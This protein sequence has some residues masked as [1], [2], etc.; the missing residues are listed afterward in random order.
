MNMN[1]I[2]FSSIQKRLFSAT[3]WNVLGNGFAR[4]IM[5]IASIFL[6]QILG[7]EDFGKWGIIRSTLSMFTLFLTFSLSV[8]AIRHLAEYRK[9]NIEK[10]G[11]ILTLSFLISII[12][13]SIITILIFL[14]AKPIAISILNDLTISVPLQIASVFI[15]LM[16]LNSVL[17][18]ALSGLENFKLIA[19][20]NFIAG[21]L[22]APLIILLTNEYSLNGITLGYVIYYMILFICLFYFFYKEIKKFHIKFVFKNLKSELPVFYKFS[23]PALISGAIGAPIVF[24][25]YSY[26][27]NLEN[28]FIMIG[29]FTAAKIFQMAIVELGSQ[30]HNPLISLLSNEKE[31][32]ELF[33]LSF[34]VPI[35]FITIFALPIIVIPELISWLFYK[36]GYNLDEFIIVISLTLLTSSIMI[37]K[38]GINRMIVTNNLLW[39]GVYENIFWALILIL[40]AYFL[41]PEFG[42]I[43]LAFTFT[44]SYLI[45]LLI[46]TP[47]YYK[48][49]LIPKVL[50]LSKEMFILLVI[51]LSGPILV[52]FN[53]S[54]YLRILILI[55][56]FLSIYLVIKN[57]TK[58]LRG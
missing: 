52:Y 22:S 28:G 58:K 14:F 17:T 8:T 10:A 32:K 57:L 13:G 30:L 6:A 25:V 9:E 34:T 18:G 38:Q 2:N 45:D 7:A 51:F 31:S 21:F 3:I 49:N 33:S 24:I 15:L 53:T 56:S 12:M 19:I 39:W 55:L 23:L 1:K 5:M 29:L 11:K 54:I 47:F 48:K 26:T 4:L 42:A 41:I 44:I 40:F 50:F 16:S 35:V 43:G 20:C 37:F 36:G 46:I 27:A